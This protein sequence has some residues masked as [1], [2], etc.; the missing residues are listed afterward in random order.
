M[1]ILAI[2]QYWCTIGLSESFPG[3]HCG[4]IF[5]QLCKFAQ[6]ILVDSTILDGKSHASLTQSWWEPQNMIFRLYS[7]WIYECHFVWNIAMP[8]RSNQFFM[9]QYLNYLLFATLD[10]VIRWGLL[11]I[12]LSPIW[13]KVTSW[14]RTSSGI[15]SFNQLNCSMLPAQLGVFN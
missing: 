12:S 5:V 2:H 13:G 4:K 11:H 14:I 7:S 9:C 15:F 6:W 3:E 1:A 10:T 8:V